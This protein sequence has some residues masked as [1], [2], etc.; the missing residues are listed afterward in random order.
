MTTARAAPTGEDHIADPV[1][2]IENCSFGLGR[3]LTL[4]GLARLRRLPKVL[5]VGH[6]GRKLERT[7]HQQIDKN[8]IAAGISPIRQSHMLLFR[9]RASVL[10]SALHAG[11]YGRFRF[12]TIGM[13]SWAT[14]R[15]VSRACSLQNRCFESARVLRYP[16][17][18]KDEVCRQRVGVEGLW[19]E[20]M[21]EF[22][23]IS[24]DGVAPPVRINSASPI[25]Q[26]YLAR[27]F[28]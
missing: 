5:C 27:D 19:D 23:C 28:K 20:Q 8:K 22:W 13:A 7:N 4:Y 9:D 24:Q 11:T 3:G 16:L 15:T 14:F 10:I 25:T 21:F 6:Q 2:E 1:H 17:I 18:S 12:R 26:S